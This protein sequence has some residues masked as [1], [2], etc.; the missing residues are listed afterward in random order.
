[1]YVEVEE[2]V[3]CHTIAYSMFHELAAV[4]VIH[5]FEHVG[6]T[7]VIY[8]WGVIVDQDIMNLIDFDRISFQLSMMTLIIQ[9]FISFSVKLHN[10]LEKSLYQ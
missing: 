1:M 9:D 3:D 7:A 2:H 10:R 8:V 5:V 4:T 6:F